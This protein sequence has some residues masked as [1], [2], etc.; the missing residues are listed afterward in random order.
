MGEPGGQDVLEQVRRHFSDCLAEVEALQQ[1]DMVFRDMIIEL[2]D[3]EKALVHLRSGQ[4]PYR[5]ERVDECLGWIERLTAEMRAALAA[6]RIVP[7][8]TS[9][10]RGRS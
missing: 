4:T 2:A 8:R 10:R 6:A 7:L 3:A 9:A 5:A 1:R